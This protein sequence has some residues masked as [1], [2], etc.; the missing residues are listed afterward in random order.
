[1]SDIGEDEDNGS[2]ASSLVGGGNNGSVVSTV[3]DRFG[4]LGGSQYSPE[5]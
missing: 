1:M 5:P 2:D 3:P 4:F